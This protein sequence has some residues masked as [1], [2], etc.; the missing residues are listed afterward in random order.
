MQRDP[1][2]PICLAG[3]TPLFSRGRLR[4]LTISAVP[5]YRWVHAGVSGG[6]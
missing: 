3:L 6:F 5:A 4:R 1:G 2:A